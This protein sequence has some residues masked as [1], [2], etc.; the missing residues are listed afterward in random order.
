MSDSNSNWYVHEYYSSL[1]LLIEADFDK[2]LMILDLVERVH[3]T[4]HEVLVPSFSEDFVY[5]L[6][7]FSLFLTSGFNLISTTKMVTG[8]N[9]SPNQ[10]ETKL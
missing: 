7:F 6:M 4:N 1:I 9:W 3:K 2:I 8:F 10:K 5:Q